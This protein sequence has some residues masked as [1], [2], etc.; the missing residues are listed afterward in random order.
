MTGYLCVLSLFVYGLDNLQCKVK[1][2]CNISL[3]RENI[4]LSKFYFNFLYFLDRVI[5]ILNDARPTVIDCILLDRMHEDFFLFFS[6][7][8]TISFSFCIT[9]FLVKLFLDLLDKLLNIHCLRWA[10]HFNQWLGLLEAE[11]DSGFKSRIWCTNLHKKTITKR[12][13]S[14]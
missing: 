3:F 12:L 4:L 11:F 8:C 10:G 2:S 1:S 13:W 6:S 14:C 9:L 7:F 5:C